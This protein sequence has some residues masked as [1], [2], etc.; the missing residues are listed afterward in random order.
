MQEDYG[1]PKPNNIKTINFKI[2]GMLS[3]NF[4][5]CMYTLNFKLYTSLLINAIP[6]LP[7]LKEIKHFAAFTHN[8]NLR[9]HMHYSKLRAAHMHNSKLRDNTHLIL[10]FIFFIKYLAFC[11][12]WHPIDEDAGYT[13]DEDAD[14]LIGKFH[15][16]KHLIEQSLII[17]NSNY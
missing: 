9:A 10:K 1:V 11:P 7:P 2:K 17:L 5:L 16:A 3:L 6:H 15:V 8:S 12:L 4:E 14:P 13:I